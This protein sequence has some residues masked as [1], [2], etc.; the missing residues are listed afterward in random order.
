[1]V[2]ILRGFEPLNPDHVQEVS[3]ANSTSTTPVRLRNLTYILVIY[4]WLTL[5]YL[6]AGPHTW[7]QLF[8]C[9]AQ[10][11]YPFYFVSYSILTLFLFRFL[12]Y[13]ITEFELEL[14]GIFSLWSQVRNQHFNPSSFWLASIFSS[15]SSIYILLLPR[16]NQI[17][18]LAIGSNFQTF[19]HRHLSA[20]LISETSDHMIQVYLGFL[21]SL[22]P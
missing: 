19:N 4:F 8:S 22:L 10:T 11:L 12:F 7:A 20:V 3:I 9:T 16:C 18:R 13:L 6:I 17:L 1:M 15:A 14:H 5:F 21:E 2:T